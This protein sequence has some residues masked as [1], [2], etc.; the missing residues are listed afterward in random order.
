MFA[1][2][3][4]VISGNSLQSLILKLC[5]FQIN[6]IFFFNE[7][8]YDLESINHITESSSRFNFLLNLSGIYGIVM[9]V[10]VGEI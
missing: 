4:S 8:L 7:S 10:F 3:L 9:V 2:T 5:F 1:H 6:F